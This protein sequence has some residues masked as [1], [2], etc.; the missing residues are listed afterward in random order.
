MGVGV[1]CVFLERDSVLVGPG[2]S[3]LTFEGGSGLSRGCDLSVVRP[4]EAFGDEDSESEEIA[5]ISGPIGARGGIRGEL[6]SLAN[7][8]AR[9]SF[10]VREALEDCTT[11]GDGSLGC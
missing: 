10:N 7:L 3:L 5:Y 6:A 4:F 9:T 1:V 2:L 8:A 11:G